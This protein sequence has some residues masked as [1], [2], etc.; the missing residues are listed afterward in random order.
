[1]PVQRDNKR[2]RAVEAKASDREVFRIEWARI[3]LKEYTENTTNIQATADAESERVPVT[4]KDVEDAI[5]DV[6][7]GR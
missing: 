1:M 3:K 6:V 7:A 2:L 5:R 4:E